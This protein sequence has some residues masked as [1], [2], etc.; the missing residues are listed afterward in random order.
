MKWS[1][2]N[3]S[4]LS[5]DE[6]IL[7]YNYSTD[8][9]L[10]LLPEL[11]SIVKKY[12]NNTD[13][14]KHI[15]P[16]FYDSLCKNGF[17]VDTDIN[18]AEIA[19]QKIIKNLSSTN[20]LYL[21]IN[22][23]LDCNLRCWYCYEEHTQNCYMTNKTMEK[24]IKFVDKKASDDNLHTICLGF[25]GGEPLL[26][27]NK[28]ALPLI[29]KIKD[30]CTIHEKKL[31]LNFTTNG[32][33]LSK[34]LSDKLAETGTDIHFQIPFDGGHLLHDKTKFT[35]NG[36]GTFYRII[37]NIEYALSKEFNF[38][39]RCNYTNE[40]IES[41]IELADEMSKLTY[42]GENK[43]RFSLQKVWQEKYSDILR[44][45]VKKLEYYLKEK[46]LISEFT[47][48]DM[49]KHCYADY[50]SSVIINYNGDIFKC[51]ARSFNHSERIG[52]L[53]DDGNITET[54]R[55]KLYNIKRFRPQCRS[56]KLFPI[57]VI[58]IQKKIE[59]NTCQ[60]KEEE[61]DSQ[62]HMRL[63]AII[64]KHISV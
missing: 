18:E 41:F 2:Y 19:E 33:L 60:M 37:E 4:D 23:T 36:N 44:E 7:L 5:K 12:K 56:C 30:I 9:I 48:N 55:A 47:V 59:C 43:I 15:H 51:T 1:I 40:N 22:P 34:E 46:H 53:E 38:T 52:T 3:I 61:A 16:E 13:G 32:V 45:K 29:H 42:H 50:S 58:C 14:I 28:I 25:F 20:I 24:I 27:A 6:K 11:Y 10:V 8:K 26:K 64:E 17:I 54:E 63:K 35:P 21:T 62:L 39:I 31:K 57:C 49:P